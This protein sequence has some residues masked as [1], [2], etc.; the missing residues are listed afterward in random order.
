MALLHV[1]TIA[2]KFQKERIGIVYARVSSRKQETAGDL[3]R[4]VTAL[5]ERYPTYLVITDVSSGINFTRPGLRKMMNM[6]ANGSV[7]EVV[8]M[9]RDRIARIAYELI[10]WLCEQN[11]TRLTSVMQVDQ[12]TTQELADDLIA[13]TTVFVNRNNGRRKYKT[14]TA[15]ERDGSHVSLRNVPEC[16]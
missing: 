4:Q 11:G 1:N 16:V 13:I 9:Y 3:S 6:I 15:G 12:T 5:K 7:V 2:S 8:C 10:E 14:R